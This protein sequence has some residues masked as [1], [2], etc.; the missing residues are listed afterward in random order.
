MCSAFRS[1][2]AGAAEALLKAD[3]GGMEMMRIR[4]REHA[5]CIGWGDR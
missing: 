3:G 4:E 1:R 5:S 2:A